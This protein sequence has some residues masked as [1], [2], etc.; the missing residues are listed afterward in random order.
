MLRGERSYACFLRQKMW[1]TK[2]TGGRTTRQSTD[3]F[4]CGCSAA[5]R[6]AAPP[7]DALVTAQKAE[8]RPSLLLRLPAASLHYLQAPQ[9]CREH[10]S[11]AHPF[12]KCTVALPSPHVAL[13]RHLQTLRSL[14]R[15]QNQ[16]LPSSYA[17]PLHPCTTCR[18]LGGAENTALQPMDVDW[19]RLEFEIS[20]VDMV[21]Y[22]PFYARR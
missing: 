16:G 5:H 22:S 4:H 6:I 14:H 20:Q 21:V 12:V 2:V 15:G 11:K 9:C 18:H 13:L 17:C 1:E 7:A 3:P 8:P 10:T 19:G